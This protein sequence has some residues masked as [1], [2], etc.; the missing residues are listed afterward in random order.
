MFAKSNGAGTVVKSQTI[1]VIVLTQE[2]VE[3]DLRL[4]VDSKKR[5]FFVEYCYFCIGLAVNWVIYH[6]ISLYN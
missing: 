4:P 3:C 1:I 6:T 2:V 5:I